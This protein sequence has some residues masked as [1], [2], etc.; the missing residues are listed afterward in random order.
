MGLWSGGGT[1]S[2]IFHLIPA[3]SCLN[4]GLIWVTSFASDVIM[5]FITCFSGSIFGS[6]PFPMP[7]TSGKP[8][9]LDLA[10]N[11]V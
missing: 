4:L 9:S 3:L 10:C 5:G 1:E 7:C 6:N 2:L 8:V 11:L